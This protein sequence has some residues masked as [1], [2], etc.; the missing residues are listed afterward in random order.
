MLA[1]TPAVEVQFKT[2]R[3][4]EKGMKKCEAAMYGQLLLSTPETG[5]EKRERKR[6]E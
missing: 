5:K 2:G 3:R 6:N 4:A 1:A